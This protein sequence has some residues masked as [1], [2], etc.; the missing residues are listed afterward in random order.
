MGA[1][2]VIFGSDYPWEIPGRAVEIIQRLDLS[3]G[4]K[5]AI[6]WKNASILLE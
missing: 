3:E 4:E 2:R 6:L 5:E 1:D